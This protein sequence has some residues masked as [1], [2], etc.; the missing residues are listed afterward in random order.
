MLPVLIAAAAIA[1]AQPSATPPS[2]QDEKSVAELQKDMARG[3]L[4]SEALVKRQFARIRAIDRAGPQLHSIGAISPTALSDARARDA[5]REAGKA[6]GPLHGVTVVAKDLIDIRGMATTGGSLALRTNVVDL[7]APAIARLRAAGAVILGKATTSEWANARSTNIVTGFSGMGGLTRNP[8]VLDREASGSSTGSGVAVS[9]GL[10][11]LALG[12]DTIGS[13]IG[14][15]STNGVVGLRPTLGLIPR[16]GVIP[17]NLRMDT[18]GPMG[19]H[20]SD[21]AAMLTVLAGADPGDERSAAAD[22]HKTDYAKGL[23]PD[24]LKGV[25][26]GVVRFTVS[27]SPPAMAVFD[28]A[29]ATLR[30]Q[31]AEIVEIKDPPPEPDAAALAAA[32]AP[33]GRGE[34]HWTYDSYLSKTHPSVKVRSL[35]DLVAFNKANARE[36]LGLFGQEVLE[37][38]LASPAVA[39]SADSARR[40]DL[41]EAQGRA[42][43]DY[44]LNTHKVDALIAPANAPAPRFDFVPRGSGALPGAGITSRSLSAYSAQAAYPLLTVP[45]GDVKGLPLGLGFLGPAWSEDRLLAYGYAFEQASRARKPPQFIPSLETTAEALYAASPHDGGLVFPK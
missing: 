41:R 23:R 6:L 38:S 13:V 36:E 2:V 39:I 19:R 18:I 40:A 1:A 26:L 21:V 32:A 5:E 28:K 14:P 34:S 42:R 37:A 12:T 7:D 45:M 31:G 35:A 33:P 25:R 11:T 30:A 24:A 3:T 29:L 22:A 44:L 20:V 4:T 27:G 43:V 15:S 16:T 10:A 9:A 8:Y 17:F